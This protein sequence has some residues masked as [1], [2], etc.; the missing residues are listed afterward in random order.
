L[1]SPTTSEGAL[2]NAT[3]TRLARIDRASGR[4]A[5]A[6]PFPFAMRIAVAGGLVWI[7]PNTQYAG[8]AAT[9]SRILL[10]V[11]A[12]S[13]A[14]IFHVTL[15]ND[16]APVALVANVASNSNSVW[17]AYAGHLYRLA[18]GSGAMLASTSLAGVATSVAL[19]PSGQ[20]V[21]VGLEDVLETG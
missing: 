2:S 17:V 21:Y 4:V 1:Y 11:D 3:D 5:T 19:D 13:L 18:A 12:R 6:G 14:T 15:P 7:G 10:G 8:P 20:R 16:S 9:D